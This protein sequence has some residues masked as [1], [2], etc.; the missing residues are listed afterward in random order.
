MNQP[1]DDTLSEFKKEFIQYETEDFIRNR[2]TR[3]FIT[4]DSAV[5]E[6]ESADFTGVTINR[7]TSENIWYV[8]T[9]RLKVNSRELIDHLFHLYQTQKPEFIGLE[10]TTFT[11]AIQPFLQEE[12]RLRQTFFSVTPVKHRGVNKET[13]I[14]GLI[15]RYEN[16]GIV[17]IGDNQE[18]RDEMR[19]FPRGQ[20]DD[21]LDSLAMQLPHAEPPMSERLQAQLEERQ[22]NHTKQVAQRIGVV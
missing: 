1:V 7:V 17:F 21:V 11:Q 10:E 19:T 15:P 2:Q 5:S 16:R 9:Y 22:H 8:R 14:R 20:F 13:R 18:L 3:C 12:M 4:I 6:K